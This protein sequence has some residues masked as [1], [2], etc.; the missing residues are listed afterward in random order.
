MTK[1]ELEIITPPNT[2]KTKV[3]KGGPGAINP[4]ML[5]KAEQVLAGLSDSYLE[6][7]QQ[8]LKNIAAAYEGLKAGQGDQKKTLETIFR[9]AHDM[10]GQGGSFGYNLVTSVGNELCRM[11][12][13]FP[14][15]ISAAHIDAIGVHID[16]LK[17]IVAQK[18]K[19]DS[20]STGA[21]IL[22]GLQK[23]SAKLTA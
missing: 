15:T 7:V 21:A 3:K 4:A 19:G 20:G 8:D 14:A 23:V 12:E 22:A 5:E 13:K 10:K 18:M 2:L 11:I 16:S 1:E 9:I 6:W 17:L